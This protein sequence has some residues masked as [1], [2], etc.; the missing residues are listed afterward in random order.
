MSETVHRP[1]LGSGSGVRRIRIL[2]A[3]VVILTAAVLLIM[4]ANK[5]NMVYYVTVSE[6]LGRG[7]E[8]ARAGLRVAG[9][10]VPGSIDRQDQQLRFAVTDGQKALPV[11]YKGVIPDTFNEDGDVVVEGRY[12]AQG[13]FEASF[14]MAKCPSKYQAAPGQD[15]QHPAGIP[16][17]KVGGI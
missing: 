16:K 6:L 7:Q 9:K 10:V 12:T 3:C 4:R 1:A 11:V 14:L 15:A 17:T 2:I 5:N 8:G 13:T